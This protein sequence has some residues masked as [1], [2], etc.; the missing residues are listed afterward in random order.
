ML[1]S[2]R[3]GGT[4]ENMN[5]TRE[6]YGAALAEFGKSYDFYVLDADLSKATQTIQFAKKFPD[7][8]FD[9]G[10]AE[11]NMMGYAAGMATCGATVFVSTFAAFAAGR[12]YD[13]IRNSIAYPNLNV[14]IGATHGGILIGADGGSHQCIEDIA[15]MQAIPGMTVLCPCDTIETYACVKAAIKHNGPV[16]LRF[17]RCR[18]PEVYNDERTFSFKIGKGNVVKDGTDAAVIAVGDMVS[19]AVIA[20]R[21]L[22]EQGINIAV[23]DLASIKP[24]DKDLIISY[25]K[26]TGF[27][28]T[29]EED[30]NVHG[31]MG[32]AVSEVLSVNAPTPMW[33]L[34]V[35]DKFGR[36]GEPDELAQMYGLTWKHIVQVIKE[37]QS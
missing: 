28:V 4:I 23:L 25:A 13:Q 21:A 12:A 18:T 27:V 31:G 30:H 36:S 26:K 7:R 34:G 2:V 6:A 5:S 1:L 35:Q 37:R 14:K 22:A 19:Q 17:G 9:M 24:I 20:S 16:Y 11:C 3:R 10:I 15:L 33:M 29:I 32:S 8:F